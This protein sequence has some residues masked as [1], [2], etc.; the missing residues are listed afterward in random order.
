MDWLFTG[1]W[2][3]DALVVIG[4]SCIAGVALGFVVWAVADM[5]RWRRTDAAELARL[6]PKPPAEKTEPFAAKED[7]R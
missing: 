2:W 3:M 5:F 7:K 1:I 6:S 4:I